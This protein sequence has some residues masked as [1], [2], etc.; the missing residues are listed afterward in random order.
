MVWG[1]QLASNT[2]R[3]GGVSPFLHY[4][5][6]YCYGFLGLLWGS[7]I[8]RMPCRVLRCSCSQACCLS[9]C[10]LARAE[11]GCRCHAVCAVFNNRFLIFL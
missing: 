6:G 7:C 1:G 8:F 2:T 10:M 4:F 5:F 9:S 3:L 11:A